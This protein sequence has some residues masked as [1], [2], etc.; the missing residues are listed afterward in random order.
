MHFELP[1]DGQAVF[2]DLTTGKIGDN[3]S[4]SDLM[5]VLK[6]TDLGVCA[7]DGGIWLSNND[8]PY[9][10]RNDY[11]L[12]FRTKVHDHNSIVYDP[13][14]F[15]CLFFVRSQN[16]RHYSRVELDV[17]SDAYGDSAPVRL[18]YRTNPTGSRDLRETQ[19]CRINHALPSAKTY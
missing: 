3:R 2:V 15:K 13:R 8:M 19:T 7:I 6:G 5:L 10:P 4:S 11:I 14:E 12:G 9:A 17:A 16:D 1:R 18:R